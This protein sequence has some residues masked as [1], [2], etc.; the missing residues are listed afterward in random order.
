MTKHKGEG[1]E[2]SYIGAVFYISLK[3]NWYL[4]NCFKMLIV[5][6]RAQILKNSKK[7]TSESKWYTRKYLTQK[8]QG[9]RNRGT[10]RHKTY[11]KQIAK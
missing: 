6:P 11:R 8:S 9:S 3:V 5:I 2:W 7:A 10:K 1:E 4:S